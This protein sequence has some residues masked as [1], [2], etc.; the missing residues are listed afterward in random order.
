M[1]GFGDALKLV[2]NVE[3]AIYRIEQVEKRLD[4][5]EDKQAGILKDHEHFTQKEIIL[6]RKQIKEAREIQH[7]LI[8]DVY[9][10]VMVKV[11]KLDDQET[12]FDIGH[13]IQTQ[14]IE[15]YYNVMERTHLEEGTHPKLVGLIQV[16]MKPAILYIIDKY[17]ED[18][19]RL[20]TTIKNGTRRLALKNATDLYCRELCLRFDEELYKD[21]EIAE[22]F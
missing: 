6:N 4:K 15:H 2:R 3:N 10:N 5:V 21:I 14:A 11:N 9:D 17:A 22:E 8:K 12:N 19:K 1:S 18:Y 7:K 13:R 16:A 20:F